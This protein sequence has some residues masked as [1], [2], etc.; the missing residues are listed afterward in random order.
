MK[1]E[2]KR[3][4][5]KTHKSIILCVLLFLILGFGGGYV[6]TMFITKNDTFELIGDKSVTLNLNEEYQEKG[7]KAISFGKDL[8]NKVTIDSN[9]DINK[10]GEYRII[11]TINSSLKYKNIKRVRYIS[12]VNGSDN[13]G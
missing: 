6:T 2:I 9:L 5:K 13:N 4:V 12:V 7:V 1:R 3:M 11:Y 8:T 10:V